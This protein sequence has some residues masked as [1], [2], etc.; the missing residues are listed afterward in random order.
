MERGAE[1]SKFPNPIGDED[2]VRLSSKRESDRKTQRSPVQIRPPTIMNATA[3][4]QW[5]SPYRI[6]SLGPVSA[7]VLNGVEAVIF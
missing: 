6:V 2:T 3:E 1:E 4:M 7:G 5:R